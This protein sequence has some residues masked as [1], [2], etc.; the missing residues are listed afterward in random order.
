M[1]TKANPTIEEL[2]AAQSEWMAL[3]SK[4]PKKEIDR[5][6]AI[7]QIVPKKHIV[8]STNGQTANV[9]CSGP[10]YDERGCTMERAKKHAADLGIRTDIAWSTEGKFVNI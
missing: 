5:V 10:L 9:Y 4:A 3:D 1:K 2:N 8:I 6:I 7:Y